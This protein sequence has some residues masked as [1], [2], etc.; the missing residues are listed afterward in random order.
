MYL[1]LVVTQRDADSL[2]RQGVFCPAY[3]LL[4]GDALS[5]AESDR[6]KK[7]IDWFERHLPVP[8]RTKLEPMAILWFK[9]SAHNF[10]RQIWEIVHILEEYGYHVETLKTSKPGYIRYEDDYQVGAR[11]FRDSRID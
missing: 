2:R 5:P 11:P 3:T 6:L 10:I 8:D 9:P 1:R 7:I 4:W